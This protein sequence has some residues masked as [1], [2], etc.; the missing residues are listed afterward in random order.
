VKLPVREAQVVATGGVA[1]ALAIPAGGAGLDEPEA[2]G[3]GERVGQPEVDGGGE[4][5]AGAARIVE[6]VGVHT[7]GGVSG[8]RS[9]AVAG[10]VVRGALER[11]QRV[12]GM[13]REARDVGDEKQLVEP[14]KSCAARSS[15]GSASAGWPERR[16]TSATRSSSASETASRAAWRTPG[17]PSVS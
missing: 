15:A 9:A 7:A 11:G 17:A 10:E 1:R 3:L 13:A 12:G 2:G 8:E 16:A 5:V 4:G 14:G 6:L